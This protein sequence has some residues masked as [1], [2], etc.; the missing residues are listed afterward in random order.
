MCKCAVIYADTAT[1][2]Y[3]CTHKYTMHNNVGDQFIC[4][5]S[6]GAIRSLHSDIVYIES[7]PRLQNNFI[8]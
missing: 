4:I 7:L 1:Y 6:R 2:T 8:R 5:R 3:E